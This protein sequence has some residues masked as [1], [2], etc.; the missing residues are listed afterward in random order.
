MTETNGQALTQ[1]TTIHATFVIERTYAVAPA[2]VWSA[3]ADPEHPC[4]I[5][6][7]ISPAFAPAGP[8]VR[9]IDVLEEDEES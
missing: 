2:R 1:R 5:R 4:P 9:R 8:R 6:K 7:S 3:W